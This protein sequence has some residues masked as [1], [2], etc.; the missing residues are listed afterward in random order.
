MELFGKG[1][2]IDHCIAFFRTRQEERLYRAYITDILKVTAEMVAT[3][4]GAQITARDFME[5]AGW[6]KTDD[7]TGDEIAADIIK[8]AGLKVEHECI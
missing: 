6:V 7:R 4:T 3:Y 2:V 5:L 1:Y 8:R